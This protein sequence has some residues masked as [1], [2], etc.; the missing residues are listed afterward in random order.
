MNFNNLAL[1]LREIEK[2]HPENPLDYFKE[3]KLCLF[4]ACLEKYFP[5][6]R[7]G[8]QDLLEE[9]QLESSTCLNQSCCSGTFFQRNLITRAQFSAINER[10]LSEMNQQAEIAFISCNGCYNSLLRGRDFLK[11]P[12]VRG[13]TQEIL[14]SVSKKVEGERYPGIYKILEN[15][16]LKLVHDLDFLYLIRNDVL[17]TLKFDL[18]DLKVAVHYGC[19]YLNLSRDKKTLDSYLGS[20]TKFE[21]LIELFGGVPVD[22]QE[23]E[24]CC[25]WGAS[26]LLINPREA[27]KITYN[28]LKSAENVGADFLLM[29]CPT[30]LYTLSKPEYRDN[31]EKWFGEKLEIPTIH[32]NELISILRGCEKER[33]ISLTQKTPRLE[34]IFEII[35]ED[36]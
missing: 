28:K 30:C 19:H 33:C 15:P 12:E 6:V 9:L 5:G 14:N 10:N 32:L 17:N 3:K 18:K 4:N 8:F 34:E 16:K 1:D 24:S 22:Y 2:E 31:I 29:P 26:Q 27:L 23:R 20:K 36:K 25:G 35:T 7:W 11:N 21:E 13:K